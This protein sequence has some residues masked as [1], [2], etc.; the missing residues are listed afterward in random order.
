[1]WQTSQG[2]ACP[3]RADCQSRGSRARGAASG[4]TI[5]LASP[6]DTAQSCRKARQAN[7]GW[8]A[9]EAPSWALE[10]VGR[11]LLSTFA[12]LLFNRRGTAA[13]DIIAVH[14]TGSTVTQPHRDPFCHLRLPQALDRGLG[15]PPYPSPH[16]HTLAIAD[17]PLGR[18]HRHVGIRSRC[19]GN[20]GTS[21]GPD[22]S[23]ARNQSLKASEVHPARCPDGAALMKI[24]VLAT[25]V[26]AA[27]ATPA[28]AQ[29]VIETP[30]S[31]TVIVP[32]GAP[33]VVTRQ[34]GATGDGFAGTYS[35]TGRPEDGITNDS[36]AGSNA[37]QPSRMGSTS[38]GGGK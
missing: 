29:A 18:C 14:P 23:F 36:A 4:C 27:L 21:G 15:S 2:A 16:L 19:T 38:G 1:M 31:T 33:G 24:F 17:L 22:G 32:P 34:G 35:P 26:G 11:Y 5:S 20:A 10:P 30:T 37:G 3:R 7:T 9:L 28:F 6:D 8:R 25:V 12:A 13:S